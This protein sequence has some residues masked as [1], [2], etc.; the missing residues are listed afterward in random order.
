MKHEDHKC[1]VFKG[2][3]KFKNM[4][5]DGKKCMMF[6]E[7]FY[8]KKHKQ[9]KTHTHTHTHTKHEACKCI[10]NNQHCPRDAVVGQ[11]E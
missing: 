4:K 2:K 5:H 3:E 8:K 10:E 1:M 9:T 11:A 7:M 6:D